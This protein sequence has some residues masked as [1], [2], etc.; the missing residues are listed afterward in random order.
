MPPPPLPSHQPPSTYRYSQYPATP[1]GYPYGYPHY[2]P[3]PPPAPSYAHHDLCYSSPYLHH[4]YPPTTYRRFLP[5]SAQYYAPNPT[6]IYA[7]PP[8]APVPQSQ[9]VSHHHLFYCIRDVEAFFFFNKLITCLFVLK[10]NSY[11]HIR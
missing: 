10:R 5:P 3:T 11:Y 4:K 6:D 1:P 7:S 8:A 2:Y 9:Q